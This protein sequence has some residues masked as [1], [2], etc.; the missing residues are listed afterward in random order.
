MEWFLPFLVQTKIL[1]EV[2]PLFSPRAT[3]SQRLRAVP[4]TH[5]HPNLCFQL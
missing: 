1:S 2:T 5:L 3:L 4:Y